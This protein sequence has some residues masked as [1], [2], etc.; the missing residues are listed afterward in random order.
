M[1][2]KNEFLFSADLADLPG[3]DGRANISERNFDK[4]AWFRGHRSQCQW[5]LSLWMDAK[6]LRG[7]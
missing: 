1:E 4:A 5:L 3:H 7:H 6:W 2:A